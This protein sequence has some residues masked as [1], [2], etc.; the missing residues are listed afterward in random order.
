MMACEF[1]GPKYDR[2][3]VDVLKRQLEEERP[4]KSGEF[5]SVMMAA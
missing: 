1:V 5:I 2:E 4:P 3:P